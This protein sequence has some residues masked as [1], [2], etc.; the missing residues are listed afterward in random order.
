MVSVTP[1]NFEITTLNDEIVKA[2][3]SV[4]D[5]DVSSIEKGDYKHFMLKEIFEQPVS[6]ENAYRGRLVA[7]LATVKLGGLNLSPEEF[8]EIKKIQIIACGT[9][10]HSGLIG[11]YVIESLARIPVEVEYASEFRYK[12]PLIPP[13]TIVFVIS[14]SGETADTLAA[15]RE[16]QA[17]GVKV[18]GITNVVG[19]SIARETDGGVYIHAGAEIGVASTKAFTSQVTVLVSYWEYC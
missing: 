17:R 6:V 18:F 13:G 12:N 3:I 7:N 15:L 1:D 16:A 9:S 10:W 11:K 2:K 4:V 19:S 14:Q 8:R 5:W